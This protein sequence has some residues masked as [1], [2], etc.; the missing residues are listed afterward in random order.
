MGMSPYKRG[1]P[2]KPKVPRSFRLSPL[3][4]ELLDRISEEDGIDNTAVLETII[5]K[6]AAGRGMDLKAVQAEID[7]RMP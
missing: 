2:V 5:R 6:E 7:K 1:I 4:D 3:A